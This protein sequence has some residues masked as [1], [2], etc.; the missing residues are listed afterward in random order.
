MIARR[1]LAADMFRLG[2]YQPL[3]CKQ[4]FRSND[5]VGAPGKKIRWNPQA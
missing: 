1:E 2:S 5:F 3:H 4:L